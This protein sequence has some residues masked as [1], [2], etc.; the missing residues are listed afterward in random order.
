MPVYSK[1]SI[2]G[3]CGYEGSG[4]A[5][6]LEAQQKSSPWST[7]LNSDKSIKKGFKEEVPFEGLGK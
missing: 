1:C 6:N 2:N 7:L 4:C 5:S 3:S